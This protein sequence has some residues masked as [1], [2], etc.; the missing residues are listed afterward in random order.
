MTHSVS[1]GAA[2][3]RTAIVLAGLTAFALPAALPELASA[4]S[5]DSTV[6]R[7]ESRL[8]GW[9]QR[10]DTRGGEKNGA[11]GYGSPVPGA[12][13]DRGNLQETPSAAP[14]VTAQASDAAFR[15]NQLEEQVRVLNGQIE[16]M[17]FQLLQLQEQLRKMQE[18]NEFRFQELEDRSDASGG[19][20]AKDNSLGKSKPSDSA[21]GNGESDGSD[22]RKSLTDLIE[23]N[24]DA[25]PALGEPPAELGTLTFDADGNLVDSNVGKPID[26][27]Q[28]GQQSSLAPETLPGDAGER[29]NLGYQYVQAGEYEQAE[30]VFRSFMADFNG[31]AKT[32][33][34]AFWLGESLFS[35]GK[36]EEAARIFLENHKAYP[37]APLAA[38]NLLKLG[39]SL[40]GLDQR[41]LACA[42]YAEVPKKYPGMSNAVRKR[43]AIEQQAAKCKNG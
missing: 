5:P 17:N 43:V 6:V 41:E 23:Q 16:E 29:F 40:A 21:A 24:S 39:V 15:I 19:A 34:A 33:D 12:A 42:T 14:I 3:L 26:L 25:G 13:L 37:Q 30:Q 28:P 32:S 1:L 36:Y 11:A 31:D 7:T 27:T 2:G 4:A 20:S 35:Q 22:T 8:P 9:L 10:L 18:D 38:Q